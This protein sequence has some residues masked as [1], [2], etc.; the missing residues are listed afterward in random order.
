MDHKIDF[1][2]KNKTRMLI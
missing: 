2:W 1:I